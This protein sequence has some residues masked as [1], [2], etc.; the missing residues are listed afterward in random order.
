MMLYKKQKTL[1]ESSSL[2]DSSEFWSWRIP[3]VPFWLWASGSDCPSALHFPDQQTAWS[4]ISRPIPPFTEGHLQLFILLE[5][6][7]VTKLIIHHCEYGARVCFDQTSCFLSALHCACN[8]SLD[9][10]RCHTQIGWMRFVK[11]KQN[12]I[13]NHSHLFLLNYRLFP[14]N[15]PLRFC[16]LSFC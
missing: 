6:K 10:T 12:V 9:W 15:D 3:A 7:S 11:C 4:Q 8:L 13:L 14:K 16:H 1:S 2:G 5:R